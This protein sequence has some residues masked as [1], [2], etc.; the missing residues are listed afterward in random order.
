MSLSDRVAIVSQPRGILEREAAEAPTE[1]CDGLRAARGIGLAI[2]L[3]LG[4]WMPI[5]YALS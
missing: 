5:I 1:S 3:G 2:L 4:M